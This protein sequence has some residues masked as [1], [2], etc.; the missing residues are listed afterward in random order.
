MK[1]SMRFRPQRVNAGAKSAYNDPVSSCGIFRMR[2]QPCC[3]LKNLVEA[4]GFAPTHVLLFR[5]QQF[6]AVKLPVAEDS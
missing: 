2:A 6:A 4:G 3:R 1:G 5:N